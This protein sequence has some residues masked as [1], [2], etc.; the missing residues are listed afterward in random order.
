M[1]RNF[2]RLGKLLWIDDLPRLIHNYNHSVH[3]TLRQTPHSVWTKKAV[4]A[5]RKIYREPFPFREG[6]PVRTLLPRELFDKRAGAQKWSDDVFTIA[7]REGFKYVVRDTNGREESTKYRPAQL[8]PVPPAVF[9][10]QKAQQQQRAK[11]STELQQAVAKKKK[12]RRAYLKRQGIDLRSI[13]RTRTRSHA[14]G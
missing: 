2:A 11:K 12:R 8:Y 7:R 3:S 9:E 14:R 13:K 1:G 4:P 6:Q 10:R 5:P